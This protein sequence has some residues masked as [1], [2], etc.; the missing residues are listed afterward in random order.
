MT[1]LGAPFRDPDNEIEFTEGLCPT[2]ER[3][4]KG[5][6]RIGMNEFWTGQDMRDAARAICKAAGH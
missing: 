2:A 6:V 3:V 5:M 1:T 4:L